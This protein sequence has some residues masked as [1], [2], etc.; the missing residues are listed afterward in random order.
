MKYFQRSLLV[1][2]LFVVSGVA[3]AETVKKT[4]SGICHPPASSYYERT[5]NFR[6]FDSVQGCLA[7][8]GRL[9]NG[10]A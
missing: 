4:S 5:K 1:A 2:T 7:S 9:P 3:N 6:P 8:G 10:L